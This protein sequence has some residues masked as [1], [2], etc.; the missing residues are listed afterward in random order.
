MK[1]SPVSLFNSYKVNNYSYVSAQLQNRQLSNEGKI[2]YFDIPFTSDIDYNTKIRES[3]ASLIKARNEVEK[4]SGHA[5]EL[6]KHA[7]HVINDVTRFLND[8]SE[9]GISSYYSDDNLLLREI[10]F[11][12]ST[13]VLMKEYKDGE[14]YRTTDIYPDG[15]M[16]IKDSLR[17]ELIF[18]NPDGSLSRF[19]KTNSSDYPKTSE[20]IDS[21][22]SRFRYTKL[23]KQNK[24]SAKTSSFLYSADI[25]EPK[26][27]ITYLKNISGRDYLHP[28]SCD[29]VITLEKDVQSDYGFAP[30]MFIRGVQKST[31]GNLYSARN[32]LF[33]TFAGV[34]PDD[35]SVTSRILAQEPISFNEDI[36][37]RTGTDFSRCENLESKTVMLNKDGEFYKMTV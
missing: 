1:I 28:K 32:A 22:A 9:N 5:F 14:E 11:K 23:V 25:D 24:V 12:N 30:V 19:E 37:F 31:S 4:V 2:S 33:Y 7:A 36:K 18:V 16:K 35:S 8:A 20:Y 27:K 15:S 17:K 29:Y 26:I 6:K 21:G 34:L 10:F 13:P 3:Y